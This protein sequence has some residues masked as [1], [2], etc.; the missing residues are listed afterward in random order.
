VQSTGGAARVAVVSAQDFMDELIAALREGT[1]GQ[2]RAR[3]RAVDAL[4]VDDVQFV[5]GKERTQD[6]LVHV[7]NALHGDGRQVVLVSDRQPR[8]L[9]G[10]EQR[11]RSRFEGGLVVEMGAP[12][13][14]LRQ[15]LAARLLADIAPAPA[16]ELVAYV[17][18][19]PAASVRELVGTV[20]R[21]AAEAGARGGEVTLAVA[22]AALDDAEPMPPA[23]V[24]AQPAVPETAPPPAR[25]VTPRSAGIMPGEPLFMDGE[26]MVL[27]WP[28]VAGRV[29]EELR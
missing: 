24:A 18:S 12:D 3:Y 11:L 8:E 27:D 22:R 4:L 17:A 1:V 25:P 20:N 23:D 26:K 9:E 21:I 5:A 14:E 16:P 10:L 7:F 19:R 28:D 29:I 2:W 15:R 6:E 13:P